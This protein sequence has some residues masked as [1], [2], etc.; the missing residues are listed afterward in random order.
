MMQTIL[1]LQE[2][3]GKLISMGMPMSVL[4]KHNIFEKIISIKYDVPNNKLSMFDD[5]KLAID[6]FYNKVM[7]ENA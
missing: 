5:Y 2:K 1:Y 3:A 6:N 7:E 4:K